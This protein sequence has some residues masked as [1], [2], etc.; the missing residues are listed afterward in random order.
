ML[1]LL[2][3]NLIWG[4]SEGLYRKDLNVEVLVRMRLA[5]FDMAGD[6][7]V[8]PP[9]QFDFTRVHLQLLEHFIYGVMTTKGVELYE[10][11]KSRYEGKGQMAQEIIEKIHVNY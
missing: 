1:N 11:L 5:Q 10:D 6:M 9:T 2:R 8:F 7:D 4:I 3:D